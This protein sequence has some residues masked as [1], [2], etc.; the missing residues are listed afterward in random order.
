VARNDDDFVMQSLSQQYVK[1]VKSL[2]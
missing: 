1:S 2:D